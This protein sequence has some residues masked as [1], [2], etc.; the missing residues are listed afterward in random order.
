MRRIVVIEDAVDEHSL[1]LEQILHPVVI[2]RQQ[3]NAAS[4]AT[5][6]RSSPNLVIANAGAAADTAADFF[7]W[8]RDHRLHVPVLGI[9]DRN[10]ADFLRLG[11]EAVDEFVVLPAHPEELRHRVERLAPDSETAVEFAEQMLQEL[12]FENIIG[13]DKAFAQTLCRIAQFAKSDATILLNGETGT[14]KE[15]CARA[16]HTLSARRNSP[17]VPVECSALPDSLFE[18][19][20]FGHTKGAYTGAHSDQKGLIA[21]ANGG[22]VFLDEV[23]SLSL[24]AQG[25]LLRLLQESSFRPLGSGATIRANVRVIAAC[26][27]DLQQLVKEKRFRA[28]L[29]FRLN[30]LAVELPPLRKRGGDVAILAR[31]FAADLCDAN[32]IERRSFSS[33]AIRKLELHHWPGNVRE[34]YNIVHRAVLIS[35]GREILPAHIELAGG[36]SFPEE[37]VGFHHGRLCAIEAFEADY[38]RRLMERHNGNVTRAAREAGKE[39]RSFGRLVKKYAA[40]QN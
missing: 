13:R 38:V 9:F 32:S 22:T 24:A 1:T 25:K 33:A 16:I 28:D 3:W 36:D 10:D 6:I 30:V 34:L 4:P 17:F 5:V 39:R 40:G 20:V 27:S 12:A 21:M 35:P 15:L 7:R 2:H 11:M 26:N 29:F 14:G 37:P 8:L 19:E 18:S 23:D 31:R